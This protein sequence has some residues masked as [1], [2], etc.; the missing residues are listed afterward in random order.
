MITKEE[1]ARAENLPSELASRLD[2]PWYYLGEIDPGRLRTCHP[3]A[4]CRLH[5]GKMQPE[6]VLLKQHEFVTD[7][8]LKCIV[9]FGVCP[10]CNAVLWAQQGPPFERIR[11]IPGE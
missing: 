10:K 7:D 9:C 5:R 2:Q 1:F 6:V 11:R 3:V 8:L 4:V